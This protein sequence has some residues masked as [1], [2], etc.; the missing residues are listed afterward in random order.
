MSP[1]K[2]AL[3]DD[4]RQHLTEK[5]EGKVL[6]S[7][8]F[9]ES[10]HADQLQPINLQK[11]STSTRSFFSITDQ[12]FVEFSA[13]APFFLR[14]RIRQPDVPLLWRGVFPSLARIAE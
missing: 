10:C 5:S 11:L 6:Q 1:G 3:S 13:L 9:T 8:R 12:F 7:S 4:N 2:Q 14:M